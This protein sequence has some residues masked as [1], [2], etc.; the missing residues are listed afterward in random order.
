MRFGDP[1]DEAVLC[2]VSEESVRVKLKFQVADVHK[3]LMAV[4]RLVEKG[5]RVVFGPSLAAN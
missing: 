1:V 4:R 5:S 2:P 3:S